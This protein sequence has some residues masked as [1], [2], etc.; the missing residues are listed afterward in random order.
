MVLRFPTE[1]ATVHEALFPT[2]WGELP[3]RHTSLPWSQLASLSSR[4]G[5]GHCEQIYLLEA[6]RRRLY[7]PS[8]CVLRGVLCLIA[9][10]HSGIYEH[11]L[12]LP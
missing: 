2:V 6:S 8:C 9:H 11:V 1:T 4:E 10:R 5:I 12:R 7:C 3:T